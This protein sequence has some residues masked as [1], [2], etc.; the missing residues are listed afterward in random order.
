MR[1]LEQLRLLER[2]LELVLQQ[3]ELILKFEL[4]VVLRFLEHQ[5]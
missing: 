5:R 2:F 1:I 4:L 3:L